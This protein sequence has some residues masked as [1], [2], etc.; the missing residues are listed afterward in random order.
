MRRHSNSRKR[1][2]PLSTRCEYSSIATLVRCV[3]WI[4]MCL[5]YRCYMAS[6]EEWNLWRSGQGYSVQVEESV[7]VWWKRLPSNE[8]TNNRIL[9]DKSLS[10]RINFDT[11]F[12]IIDSVFVS[13]LTKHCCC[14]YTFKCPVFVLVLLLSI[15]P[16]SACCEI[17]TGRY[18][19]G[20]L[21]I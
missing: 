5:C 8:R 12:M 21:C 7:A 18:F 19:T 9:A 10:R 4:Y 3:D 2:C 17:M 16:R 6:G 11:F 15:A 1:H 20:L 14:R 13:N